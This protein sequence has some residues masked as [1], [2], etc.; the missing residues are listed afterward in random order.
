MSSEF[1]YG[2]F[3]SPEQKGQD[4]GG[5]PAMWGCIEDCQAIQAVSF[6]SLGLPRLELSA[7]SLWLV[8]TRPS[9]AGLDAPIDTRRNP[10]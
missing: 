10:A 7:G 3:L 6:T 4:A 8:F 2:I 9:V 5:L 1:K